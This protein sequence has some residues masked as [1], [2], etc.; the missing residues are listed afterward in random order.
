MDAGRSIRERWQALH[1]REKNTPLSNNAQPLSDREKQVVALASLGRS[2][3][4]IAYELGIAH[5][6]VR[7]LFAR[8]RAN[9][10]KRG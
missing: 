8:A 5:A 1:C 3:K 6:T 9:W 7:V 10:C 4:L 2:N